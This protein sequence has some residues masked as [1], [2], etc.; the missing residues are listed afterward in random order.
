MKLVSDK[1]AMSL[2]SNMHS[3]TISHLRNLFDATR[4][5]GPILATLTAVDIP[6]PHTKRSSDLM[7]IS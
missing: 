4:H 1:D 6:G 7:V 2:K 3:A 5:V